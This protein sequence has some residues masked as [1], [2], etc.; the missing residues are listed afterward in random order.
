LFYHTRHAQLDHDEAQNGYVKEW[1][2][3]GT[4]ANE[5]GSF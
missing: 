4:L 2:K 3:S 1:R 5:A